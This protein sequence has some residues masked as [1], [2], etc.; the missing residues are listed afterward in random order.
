LSPID[1]LVYQALGDLLAPT[2]EAQLDRS[3]TFSHVVAKPGSEGHLFEP[4]HLC[5]DRFQKALRKLAR[6]G[7]VFV[8]ADVANYFERIPQH[9]LINLMIAS[10]CLTEVARLLEEILLAFQ[11][12]NSFGII[13]G[14]F[15]SDVFGN[16]Y[17]SDIDAYSEMH[18]IQSLRFV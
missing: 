8:K 11:E 12:R 1:R 7:G 16:F 3:R 18:G 10:G 13:Q 14:V 4:E 17:L 15:P 2:L 5:W 9:H 6:E